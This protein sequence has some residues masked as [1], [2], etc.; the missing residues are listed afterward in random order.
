MIRV[1]DIIVKDKKEL[2]VD[3]AHLVNVGHHA[4]K[5]RREIH[6]KGFMN[7]GKNNA[8]SQIIKLAERLEANLAV[9]EKEHFHKKGIYKAI[10]GFYKN[11]YDVNKVEI[12][13]SY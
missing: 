6:A 3:I 13:N 1:E 12:G 11:L 5:G 9:I 7:E 2:D 4:F 8:I 10:V